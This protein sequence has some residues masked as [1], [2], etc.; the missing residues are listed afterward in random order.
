MKGNYSK[1]TKLTCLLS[2]SKSRPAMWVGYYANKLSQR[3]RG[4]KNRMFE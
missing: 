1:L 2:Q 4:R 3:V